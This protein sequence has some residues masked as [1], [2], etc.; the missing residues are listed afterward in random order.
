MA[1]ASQTSE[2]F[3]SGNEL[4]LDTKVFPDYGRVEISDVG[5]RD[6]PDSGGQVIGVAHT[7]HTVAVFTMSADQAMESGQDVSVR[8]FRGT[9]ARGLGTLVFDG[10]VVFSDPPR[11]GVYQLLDDDGQ[12][13]TIDRTGPIHVQIYVKPAQDAEQVNVLIR[14]DL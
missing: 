1:A 8:V 9:D 3:M 12:E 14:Y 4:L 6:S 11:L 7:D 5:G 10:P 13:V 2:V